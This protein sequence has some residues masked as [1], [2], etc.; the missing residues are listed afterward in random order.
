MNISKKRTQDGQKETAAE[1]DLFLSKDSGDLMYNAQY[2]PAVKLADKTYVDTTVAVAIAE[3][4]AEPQSSIHFGV[5][6]KTV[7]P[8]VVFTKS[9]YGNEVDVIIPGELEIT[10]GNYGGI[11]N[12]A[13]EEGYQG[14][15]PANTIWNSEFTDSTLYGWA[16]LGNV[17]NRNFDNW[18]N[19]LDSNVGLNILDREL[20]MIFSGNDRDYYFMI[21]FTQWTA[22]NNENPMGG[23]FSYERYEFN[24]PVE[25]NRPEES[26]EVVDVV[27]EG[28]IIKRDNTRGLYNTVSETSYDSRISPRGTRWSSV[29]TDPANENNRDL[30]NARE[31]IYDTWNNAVNRN[32]QD[33]LGI[34]LIMHDLS[35]DLYWLVV[36]TTWALDNEE[37]GTVQYY[38]TLIP[39]AEGIKFADGTYM[40]ELPT[41]GGTT[42]DADGN[43][44]IADSSNNTV[45]VAAGE[46]HNIADFSGMLIVN[47]HY[48]GRIETWI[49]GSGDAFLLGYTAQGE[50]APT[51][52]VIMNSS[53]GYDWNNNDNLVGPFTFTVIKTRLGS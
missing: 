23:G 32:P 17:A 15:S 39:L 53:N 21:K 52:T 25:F 24:I 18:S 30:S 22:G 28:V 13:V 5:D 26:P 35:T 29:H 38:R 51:S 36:I 14:G 3:N 16:K 40:T 43:V 19:S 20:V 45:S 37:L 48:S 11:F 47:D 9:N 44:I 2:G 31:R 8:K 34:P 42:I 7:G 33:N 50:G 12:Y 10:R 27:S 41:T 1:I 49:A 4:V 6:L 46:K